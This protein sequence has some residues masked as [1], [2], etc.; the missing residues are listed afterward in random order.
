[1]RAIAFISAI[2]LAC[3][4]S[5]GENAVPVG[6]PVPAATNSAPRKKSAMEAVGGF[7]VKPLPPEA[8]H[9]T[10]TDLRANRDAAV[11]R[12]AARVSTFLRLSVRTGEPQEGDV[13]ITLADEGESA[14]FLDRPAALVTSEAN[15]AATAGRLMSALV[16]IMGVE[17]EMIKPQV[18]E[19][20]QARATAM[21]IGRVYRTNYKRAVQE[22]WAP[23]PTN[24][25]QQAIWDA[26]HS[27]TNAPAAKAEAA[28]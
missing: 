8:K 6:E 14:V 15:E 18:F 12:F 4:S 21:G 28:Q 5:L 26:A 25:F 20:I 1:M 9:I 11:E 24:E 7:V 22:G 23:A 2:S 10:V 17:G 27:A 13:A 3:L 16:R 19:T